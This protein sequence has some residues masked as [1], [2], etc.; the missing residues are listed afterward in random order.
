MKTLPRS[1]HCSNTPTFGLSESMTAKACPPLGLADAVGE[2]VL[3]LAL[4]RQPRSGLVDD[5]LL[6]LTVRVVE[7]GVH[8]ELCV[9]AEVHQGALADAGRAETLG[10]PEGVARRASAA[11]GHVRGHEL[12]AEL[13]HVLGASGVKPPHA[14]TT[15]FALTS[16]SDV[17]CV[18]WTPTTAPSSTIRPVTSA[19]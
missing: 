6:A 7:V 5:N 8:A 11:P 10:Q 2:V 19:P 3:V 14:R 1:T 12:A 13:F 15:F 18:T 9:E 16:Y 17:L 4:V